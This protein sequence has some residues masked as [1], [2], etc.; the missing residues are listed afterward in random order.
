MLCE[1]NVK[2]IALI[3]QASVE[4]S[5]GL[6][7]LTGETGAGKSV[8]I[9]SAMLALGGKQ[10]GDVIRKGAESGHVELIFTVDDAEKERRLS[11]LG[12]DLDE[13][14]LLIISRRLLPG[15]SLSRVNGKTVT[16]KELREIASEFIDIYGQNEHQSL[17][18]EDEHLR[19]LD[20]YL[21][22]EIAK[23]KA[24]TKKAYETY[25]AAQRLADSFDLDEAKRLRELEL[26]EYE[27]E[28][29]EQASVKEG[30]EEELAVR[31][32]KLSNMRTVMESLSAASRA[33]R[34]SR[35]DEAMDELHAAARFD[36][37]IE[38]IYEE[39]S[40][41]DE[42]IVSVLRALDGYMEDAE[43]DERGL[44]EIED[45]L[46][47]IRKIGAKYGGSVKEI[48]AYRAKREERAELLRDYEHRKNKAVNET[49]EKKKA[50]LD[51]CERLSKKRKQGA[52][53]LCSEI[54]KEL[55]DLN[56]SNIIFR[57]D[58]QSKEPSADGSDR[59]MFMAALNVGEEPKPLFEVASGGELSRVMLAI[60]TVLAETDDIPTLIFDEID[61][62]ISGRTAQKVAEKLNTIARTHQVICI[63]HLPQIAAMA[64]SH[65]VIT[66]SEDDG[67]N[68]TL[69]ERLS[70][71]E[72][73]GEL[74]RLLS[75]AE[76]TESV[77]EN[78]REMKRLA[79]G[80]KADKGLKKH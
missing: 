49:K 63:T 19:I 43:L 51:A 23:L 61:T 54:E 46:E 77:K 39:L 3:K 20:S 37:D 80:L 8:I 35:M 31:Y 56:F 16:L 55:L 78:A 50:L 4:F 12:V 65:Y 2:D 18:S 24:E 26:C 52:K 62:G 38:P 27:I 1:L 45:R 29:I 47:T 74:A 75:G 60:K 33:L 10:R 68:V 67:R 42:I 17:L 64:D 69:I 6:N 32:K 28:E 36:E 11:E 7:I 30:E 72:S 15:R 48:E 59:V 66:K 70:E 14:K 40:D 21:A 13:D 73:I 79:D 25:K 76:V 57:M 71:E 34:E 53:K 9:G 22:D 44:S 41:A 58:F 5:G